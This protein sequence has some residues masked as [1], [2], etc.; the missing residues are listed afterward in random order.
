MLV[1]GFLVAA[2]ALFITA[3]LV[4]T[5]LRLPGC[6]TWL[7]CTYLAAAT[8]IVLIGE[9]ASLADSIGRLAYAIGEAVA[10]VGAVALWHVRGRPRPPLMPWPRFV[11]RRDGAIAAFG[12]IVA[13]TFAYELVVGVTTPPN[14]WDAMHEHLARV[15]AWLH[16]DSLAYFPTHNA[17]EN[18]YPPNA[19][20]LVLWTFVLAGRDTFASMP[21]LAAELATC[22]AIFGIA[23]RLGASRCAAVFPAL[24]FPTL[25]IVALESVTPQNDLVE[26]SFVAV[27]VFF[28][29]GR[30]RQ[31]TILA[32]IA[33]GLAAG[34][35]LTF[36]FAAPA[37]ALIALA[38]LP[39]RRLAL[40]AV[41]TVVGIGTLGAYA[42]A[43]N[44]IR[45]DSIL[46]TSY[47][48]G[49]LRPD[50]TFG[51]T[52]STGARVVYR[53]GDLSGWHVPGSWLEH[54]SGVGKRVFSTFGIPANPPE[55]TTQ[56]TFQFSWRI[57]TAVS[58]DASGFGP[59]G[60]LVAIPLSI[61][62]AVA[63]ALRRTNRL[64][65]TLA[66]ALPIYV[67]AL[68]LGTRWNSYVGR[69]LITAIALVLP[70]A[71][72]LGRRWRV[73][74]L[75]VGAIGV[76]TVG[77]AHAFNPSKPTGLE[78]HD[79][80]WS[81]TRPEAQSLRREDLEP[82]LSAVAGVPEDARV[83]VDLDRLDWEYPLYGPKLKRRLVWL[84]SHEPLDR[85]NELGLHWAVLGNGVR[86]PP[87]GATWCVRTFP[88]SDWKLL[89]RHRPCTF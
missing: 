31:E 54:V 74:A 81:M 62:F 80:I 49:H 35:K 30:T 8:E 66:L 65:G 20:L 63:W 72:V 58:E 22:V 71:G 26:A 79:P 42:Y 5:L 52:A 86:V 73:A 88:A 69:F 84:P 67:V 53:L 59:L 85:A 1:A 27:A 24:V 51:G 77:V 28:L 4:A 56:E 14:N 2:V 45:T 36:A 11:L 17:I 16:Q 18:T 38:A 78:R 57:G 21:Q 68:A 48:A 46:G 29:L 40:F 32:G 87:I 60:L 43:Q 41:A 75:F 6:A 44:L 76:G 23:R 47:E 64:C 82:V 10:L 3:G 19:E 61:G 25:T 89:V 34:T 37:L 9:A 7:A 12:V 55:A 50:V 15:G 39:R 13:A 83:G 33:L 70:L